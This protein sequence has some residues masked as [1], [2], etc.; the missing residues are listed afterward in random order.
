[1]ADSTVNNLS[2]KGT[3]ESGDAFYLVDNS[4]TAT[5]RRVLAE[6]INVNIEQTT[7]EATENITPSDARYIPGDLRRYGNNI[8]E[9]FRAKA[10]VVI[11]QETTYTNNSNITTSNNVEIIG[12]GAV[13]TGDGSI[14]L[15]GSSNDT[16]ATLTVQAEVGDQEITVSSVASISAGDTIRIRDTVDSSWTPYNTTDRAGQICQVVSISGLVLTLASRVETVYPITTTEIDVLN[17]IEVSGGNF[18]IETNTTSTSQPLSLSKVTGRLENIQ[19]FGGDIRAWEIE[20]C[21]DLRLDN[22][23]GITDAPASGFQYGLSISQSQ[24]VVVDGGYYFGTRHGV[25]MGTSGSMPTRNCIVQNA[26]LANNGVSSGGADLHAQVADSWYIN[27]RIHN[28]AKLSGRNC[29][30][31]N[32]HIT[33]NRNDNVL[34]YLNP[35]GGVSGYYDCRVTLGQASGSDFSFAQIVGDISAS[36][37]NA[38]TDTSRIEFVGN[39]IEINSSVTR[40]AS[41]TFQ[42]TGTPSI[43]YIHRDNRVHG[44]ISSLGSYMIGSFDEPPSEIIVEGNRYDDF[45]E[46]IPPVGSISGSADL[47]QIQWHVDSMKVSSK[48]VT[49]ANPT[50]SEDKTIFRAEED[51]SIAEVVGVAIGTTPSVTLI[52]RHDSDRSATGTAIIS[53]T[54]VSN[55]TTGQSITINNDEVPEG[56]Y[57]WL[58]TTATAGTVDEVNISLKYRSD[59]N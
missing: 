12:N 5:D 10:G 47:T 18:R 59:P 35:A 49:I 14:S 8:D 15:D 50:S 52:L 6:G 26:E 38:Q 42:P 20:S 9:A 11:F 48:S 28:N 43:S 27:C 22:C 51:I 34:G 41:H 39:S 29:G 4:G 54:A 37:S 45:L 13:I 17:L 58:E 40:I 2:Q 1:M 33:G 56:N 19:C 36:T 25:T 30:F 57:V 21:F 16:V 7:N 24:N 3:A 31:R 55:T 53:S 44:D 46:N 32:C 23:E